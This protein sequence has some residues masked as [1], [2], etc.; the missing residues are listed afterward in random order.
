ML[1]QQSVCIWWYNAQDSSPLNQYLS[2]SAEVIC[3]YTERA[4]ER[5]S[6]IRQVNTT[7]EIRPHNIAYDRQFKQW[8]EVLPNVK[9][10]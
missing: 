2:L 4:S 1:T 3:L 6:V 10:R 5:R 7:R 9:G 8:Q